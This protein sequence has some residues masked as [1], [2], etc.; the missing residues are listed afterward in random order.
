MSDSTP[1]KRRQAATGPGQPQK[2]ELDARL[3]VSSLE[4]GM[5]VL[6]LFETARH[7]LSMTDVVAQTD[8]G[9]SAV[10]RFIYTLHHLDYL[11]RDADTKRYSLGP[12]VLR[13][14]R[15]FIGGRS[16]LDRARHA[17]M[18]LNQETRECTSWVEML[19]HEIVIVENLPSPHITA[20]A[21]AAGMRFEALSASSGQ[22][23]MAHLPGEVAQRVFAAAPPLARERAGTEDMAGVHKLLDRVRMQGYALTTKAFDQDSLSISAPVFDAHRRPVG[24]VNLSTLRSRFDKKDALAVL[25]P[26]VMEAARKASG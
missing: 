7:P 15:G 4:K 25:V 6:E 23:L 3:F 19:E 8:I 9:R 16:A 17:L 26:A 2:P 13:L 21:L 22:V 1:K 18:A 24:A 14:Y 11:S 5:A 12:K 10:Q 20:V